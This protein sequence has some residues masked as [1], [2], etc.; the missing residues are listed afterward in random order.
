MKRAKISGWCCIGS[1]G[2]CYLFDSNLRTNG[3]SVV[4]LDYSHDKIV[5]KILLERFYCWD[6]GLLISQNK[7]NRI[8]AAKV[9]AQEPF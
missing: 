3:E 8:G 6:I 2:L 9:E 5:G 4:R 1:C 7:H